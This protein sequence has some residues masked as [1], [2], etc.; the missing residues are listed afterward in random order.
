MEAGAESPSK[1]RA[2]EMTVSLAEAESPLKMTLGVVGSKSSVLVWTCRW[3]VN[4]SIALCPLEW[5]SYEALKEHILVSHGVDETGWTSCRWYSCS[6]GK[7][8]LDPDQLAAHIDTLP[9]KPTAD[10]RIKCPEN[11]HRLFSNNF[12]LD[13]HSMEH[14]G[15]RG[16]ARPRKA[17]KLDIDIPSP[18]PNP[19]SK[20]TRTVSERQTQK[21]PKRP[22]RKRVPSKP[23][24]KVG[25]KRDGDTVTQE[26]CGGTGH[27]EELNPDGPPS[28]ATEIHWP[29]GLH[30]GID[31]MEASAESVCSNDSSVAMMPALVAVTDSV[32]SDGTTIKRAQQSTAKKCSKCKASTERPTA[33][34]R[35]LLPY[36]KMCR[37][38]GVA[39]LR[40]WQCKLCQRVE[41]ADRAAEFGGTSVSRIR[42]PSTFSIL[43]ITPKRFTLD[44]DHDL[45]PRVNVLEHAV[46]KNWRVGDH[47]P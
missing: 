11:C 38:S 21:G 35:C 46:S 5:D 2:S 44:V 30:E 14:Q 33:C 18:K 42:K 41:C 17:R 4:S 9:I 32:F 3:R 28:P 8:G 16:S 39:L 13:V 36:C 24:S 26:A 6:C 25:L 37:G 19:V 43:A 31:E 40:G 34:V 7:I 1:R 45:L 23:K 10:F 27:A 22:P 29:V 12:D 47:V 20:K 15:G